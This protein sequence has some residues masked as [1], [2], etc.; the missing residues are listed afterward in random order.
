MARFTP[1]ALARATAPLFVLAL[2]VPEAGTAQQLPPGMQASGP[3]IEVGG[4]TFG[5]DA[6]TFVV[7]SDHV[8]R[9][10]FEIVDRAEEGQLHPEITTIARFLNL[11]AR[12]GVP[13]DHVLAAAVVH[14]GGFP[15]LLSDEAHAARYD[16]A[17][18][19]TRALVEELIANGVEIVLCG[20]T[21]GG[22]QLQDGE[23][24]PGVKV[25]LSAMTALNYFQAQGYQFNPW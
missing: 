10:V 7:P 13:D 5:V 14:G 23:L 15:A 20:Q 16:G 2:L 11:H 1:R 22:R 18:N 19:P 21:A 12:H 9:A 24:I 6:P 25:A 4:P 8:F 17:P 3:R